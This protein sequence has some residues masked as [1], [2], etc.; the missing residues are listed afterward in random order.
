MLFH[1]TNAKLRRR[2]SH[3]AARA[4][5]RSVR[6]SSPCDAIRGDRA[7]TF[8]IGWCGVR[9]AEVPLWVRSYRLCATVEAAPPVIFASGGL[10][11]PAL[12]RSTDILHPRC[13]RVATD[14]RIDADGDETASVIR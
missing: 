2:L 8:R 3:A 11:L 9:G 10:S 1:D 13:D 7:R 6:S 12:E 14:Y 5:P 4:Y